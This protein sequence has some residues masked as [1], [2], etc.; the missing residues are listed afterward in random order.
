[1]GRH[2]GWIAVTRDR[3]RR[4][5]DPRPR[6]ADDPR[7]RRARTRDAVRDRQGFSIVVVSEGYELP[8]PRASALVAGEA[9]AP[10]SSATSFSAAWA[11]WFAARDRARTGHESRVTVLG[12]VQRGGTPTP[13]DRV[14]A[15]RYG[16]MAADLVHDGPFGRMAAL[17]GDSTVDASLDE[18]TNQLKSSRRSGGTSPRPSPARSAR[19]RGALGRD[20][21]QVA[22][23][24][25]LRDVESLLDRS[26][27]TA[28]ISSMPRS[29]VDPLLLGAIDDPSSSRARSPRVARCSLQVGYLARSGGARMS[30]ALRTSRPYRRRCTRRTPRFAASLT[31]TGSSDSEQRDHRARRLAHDLGDHVE[32]VRAAD[33]KPDERQIRRSRKVAA[34]TS[35]TLSSREITS[36]PS[37][38]TMVAIR[39]S[40]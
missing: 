21:Q 20:E 36:C 27:A 22:V 6:A 38:V 18:A 9:R 17:H 2:T 14:L 10:T 1:M 13:R 34:A 12:H 7:G 30:I 28:M 15:T 4:R 33:T 37:P 40:S 25:G 19:G 23:D 26:A 24:D 35:A 31:Q 5:R 8:S 29:P 16:L 11:E 39:S 32:R 3:G